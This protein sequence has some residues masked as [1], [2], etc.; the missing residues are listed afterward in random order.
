MK[1][2]FLHCW[3]LLGSGNYYICPLI[4]TLRN[5]ASL[6]A[7]NSGL[8]GGQLNLTAEPLSSFFSVRKSPAP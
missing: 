1:V 4:S 7:V 3:A 2:G 6:A 8:A 5:A